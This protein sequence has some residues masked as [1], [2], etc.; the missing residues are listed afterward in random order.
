MARVVNVHSSSAGLSEKRLKEIRIFALLFPKNHTMKG[1][2]KKGRQKQ[3]KVNWVPGP[4]EALS[5]GP[6][7][8]LSVAWSPVEPGVITAFRALA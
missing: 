7:I 8:G 4:V 2:E 6:W 1:I 3:V 5:G